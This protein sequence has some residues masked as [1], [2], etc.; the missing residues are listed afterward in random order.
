MSEP[1]ATAGRLVAEAAERLRAGGVPSP[2]N[3]ARQLLAHVLG[4]G[5]LPW[6]NR[7]DV[8]S[9]DA[10]RYAELIERR[11]ERIPLQHLTGKAYFGRVEIDVGPGVFIP[12]PETET[13]MMWVSARLADRPE[14]ADRPPVVVDLCT[15]SGV[16]AKSLAVEAPSAEIY[17]VELS[18]EALPWAERNLADTGVHLVHGDM[19]DALPELD[20]RVD[21][22]VANPP[23]VP[24][25]AYDSVAVEARDHDP[26]LALFSGSDGLE[27]IR[28]LTKTA[29]RLLRPGGLLA[30][31]HAEVQADSA[32]A[33]V[34]ASR[35]FDRVRD[36]Q[37]LTGRPRFVTAVRADRSGS[38][39]LLWQ[40]GSSECPA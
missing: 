3:D 23:Y 34:V 39:G 35:Q 2:E 40:D 5:P 16:I 29:A 15:G 38:S 28:V 37:D 31:E 7:V 1:V 17:A 25:D 9:D 4:E 13:M 27:A 33:I 8:G 18:T 6:W 36:H 30:F 20:G 24:L 19:A 14:T 22:V 12:R 10:E 21:I 26:S 11:A 32:P